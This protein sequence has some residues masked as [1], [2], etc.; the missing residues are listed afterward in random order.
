[1]PLTA[2]VTA[3]VPFPFTIPVIVPTPVPP[4]ATATIPV[5][6]LAARLTIFAS[7]IEPSAIAVPAMA[8][9]T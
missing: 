9:S 7:V 3:L 1:M 5:N 4:F 8:A 2:A 6:L